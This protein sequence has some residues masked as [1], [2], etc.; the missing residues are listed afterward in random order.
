[1]GGGGFGPYTTLAAG[2][3]PLFM[4]AGDF[5]RDGIADLAIANS[6]SR[7]VSIL[8]GTRSGGFALAPTYSTGQAPSSIA[9]ADFNR[10]GKLDLAISSFGQISVRPGTGAGTFGAPGFTIASAAASILAGDFNG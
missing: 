10:D 6:G 1:T 2:E 4:A 8:M 7:S 3:T 5:N 9:V